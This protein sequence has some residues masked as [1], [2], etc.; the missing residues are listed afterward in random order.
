MRVLLVH[1][2]RRLG[3]GRPVTGGALRAEQH[4]S[5]LQ[6]A[7]YEVICI[8]RDQDGPGGFRSAADLRDTAQALRPDRI[9]CVQVED[10]P[11]LAGL[12]VPLAV[13]LFAPRVLEAAF[14]DSLPAAVAQVMGA[15]DAGDVFFVSNARQRWSWTSVL[16]LAGFDPA[17]APTRLVPIASPQG[18]APQPAPAEP[19]FVAGG[20][21]WPWQSPGPGLRRVL[22]HL[23]ARGEGSVRW[24]G[25]A[26]MLGED[27]GGWTLPVHPRLHTPGWLAY[28][29]LLDNYAG[30]TA[31]IDWM[32]H[33]LERSL[34]FSFRH[35][36]HFGAGLPV[37]SSSDSALADVLGNAGV[38][39]DDIEST[40]DLVLD[41]P[42]KLI[43]M[44]AAARHLGA[45]RTAAACSAEVVKWVASGRTHSQHK[46]PLSDSA[47]LLRSALEATQ[48]RSMTEAALSRAEAEV[49]NKREEVARLHGQI[50][51]L[52][53]TV[54]R[55][56][57]ALD[58]VAGF[59][60]E[61]VQLLGNQ[62]DR[63]RREASELSNEN[64]LLRADN[65]KKSA[66]L[67]AMDDLR[68]RLENDL[69]NLRDELERTRSS[70]GM[71]GRRG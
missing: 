36:D 48:A 14:G 3:P 66:E 49:G 12:G 38:A 50:A 22:A 7:G 47:S 13:D 35:A 51:L 59:K 20:A 5:A 21:R 4:A 34:A 37:L 44:R 26:P 54:A 57:R 45:K 40:L 61:A 28:D 1:H 56:A 71:F 70:R 41:N 60:R 19:V 39:S 24:Y 25:G 18:V 17:D 29:A 32:G 16:A 67:R 23:D 10:A 33:N 43:A 62:G 42:D 63:A 6:D 8:H 30:C 55:Q 58:E 52:T 2:G 65:E 27:S 64:A 15:L 69:V 31:A 11:A 68:A 9:I 46:G 53:D